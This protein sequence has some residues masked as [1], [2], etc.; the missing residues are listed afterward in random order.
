MR[1]DRRTRR[2]PRPR[3][4][5]PARAP[6]S[7]TPIATIDSPSAMITIKREALGEVRRRDA[8]LRATPTLS[9]PTTSIT[10]E[11]S[12]IQARLPSAK[13]PA[14][15]DQRR[16]CREPRSE[17]S[18]GARSTRVVPAPQ[19]RARCSG[20]ARRST[21]RRTSTASSWNASGTAS[22]MKN[23]AA[24]AVNMISRVTPLLDVDGVRHPCVRRPRPPHHREHERRA[25]EPRPALVSS[26][27][28]A[29]TCVNA[30]TNTRSKK[31]SM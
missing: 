31:S 29:V 17:P 26:R 12:Q 19:R 13:P 22:A 11:A 16:R 27:M 2:R 15:S 7:P 28:S 21:R 14:S 8:P 6:M 24:I 1:D 23:I 25:R 9:V 30:N 5:G 18:A 10:R 4:S 3:T 20:C